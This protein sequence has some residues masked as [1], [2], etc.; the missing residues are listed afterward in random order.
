L[1]LRDAISRG[2]KFNLGIL[3]SSRSEENVRAQRLRVLSGLLPNVTGNYTQTIQQVNLEAQGLRFNAP[4]GSPISIPKIVGPFGNVDTRASLS[5]TV[6]DLT[7]WK[8]LHS[9]DASIRAAQLNIKDTQDLVVQAVANS[10]LL[11]IADVAR[12]ETAQATVNTSQA[13][14]QRAVDQ[15]SAGTVAA[16]DQLRA[17][18]QLKTDQQSL[19][20]AQNQLEKDKLALGRVIGLPPGQQFNIADRLPFAPLE[21]MT[22]DAAMTQAFA[23]RSDYRAAQQQV[24]AAELAR[25][26]ARAEY[27]PTVHLDANYGDSGV[28]VG[29]SHG[30]FQVSGELRFNIFDGG[31]IKSDVEQADVTV[32]QRQDALGDLRGRIDYEIRA[33]LLDLHNAADQVA[34]AERNVQLASETLIQARDR[35]S[36]G[37]TDNIEVVQAQQSVVTAN[38]NYINATYQHN[39]AKVELAR[40]LGLAEENLH[41]FLGGK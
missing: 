29:H 5:Q 1:S 31:R 15:K 24:K 8:N 13:L 11:I 33:A 41:K 20:A 27:L 39:I 40:S 12:V 17:E 36:A 38:T 25:S 7:Q 14:F 6:V 10:Y 2:L 19:L 22:P 32:K 21:A 3:T 34:V 18:V 35:F 4:P 23:N 9:A 30:V 16:I 26:A 37:V 28:N